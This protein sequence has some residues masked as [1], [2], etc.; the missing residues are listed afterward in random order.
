MPSSR[1]ALIS[2]KCP[3]RSPR[4]HALLT[5]DD[6]MDS[7][8]IRISLRKREKQSGVGN[9]RNFGSVPAI[10]NNQQQQPPPSA[11][12]VPA[13]PGT[14]DFYSAARGGGRWVASG[15]TAGGGGGVRGSQ[16]FF[17]PV[18][19]EPQTLAGEGFWSDDG[20][21]GDEDDDDDA[22]DRSSDEDRR[23]QEMLRDPPLPTRIP[24]EDR[25]RRVSV[26]D[27][28]RHVEPELIC[29]QHS[30]PYVMLLSTLACRVAGP[31]VAYLLL[32]T[33]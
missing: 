3:Y 23:H 15:S 19:E 29:L 14:F 12:V 33:T 17:R 24:R 2:Y 11:G 1:E 32:T 6:G 28:S 21:G 13:T 9:S 18:S 22:E 7:M 4:P 16:A 26:E 8:E 10:M 31:R 20:G 25:V 5:C 27:F 30:V